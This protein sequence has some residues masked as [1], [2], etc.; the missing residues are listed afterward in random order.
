LQ[1]ARSVNDIWGIGI[2]LRQLGQIHLELGETGRAMDLIRQSV[3]QFRE[4]GDSM[5]MEMSLIDM[6]AATRA[7][8]AYAESKV[9]FLEALQTAAGTKN[10]DAVLNTLTE[11]A[12]TE[13]EE[14]A[15]ERAL[16]LVIQCQQHLSTN[17]K[18]GDQDES[19]SSLKLGRWGQQR[20]PRLERLQAELEAQLLPHSVAEIGERARARTL[21]SVVR[22]LLSQNTGVYA[23]KSGEV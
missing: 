11:I 9:Y 13:M 7:S 2:I 20:Y 14:G 3:S 5:L 15:R 1:I 12:A 4:V 10:W 21:D 18:V 23:E 17:R 16:G 6:G 8:G 22:E 19:E